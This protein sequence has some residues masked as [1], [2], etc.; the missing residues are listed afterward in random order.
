M[1]KGDLIDR[2]SSDAGISKAQADRAIDSVLR[3][4]T[5]SLRKGERVTLVGFGTFGVSQRRARR[6]VNPQTNE[7]I[8]IPA[9]KGVRFSAGKKLKEVVNKRKR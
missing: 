4:I 1:N 7:A 3:G 6:G 2:V 9:T 5:D 8:K